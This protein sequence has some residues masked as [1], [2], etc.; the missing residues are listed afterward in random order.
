MLYGL[1]YL[2]LGLFFS[3]GFREVIQ[4]FP[5][6]V[7]GIILTF[8]GLALMKL[9]RDMTDSKA[10]FVIALMVGLMAT[11]LPYGYII[12]LLVGTFLAYLAGRRV[13]KLAE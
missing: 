10:D 4:I 5:P 7:L 1:L 2:F 12:G 9:I 13:V 11:T 6:P 3:S 8:E